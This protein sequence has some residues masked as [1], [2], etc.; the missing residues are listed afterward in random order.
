MYATAQ[1]P[2]TGQSASWS[3]KP[4]GCPPNLGESAQWSVKPF[5]CNTGLSA[6]WSVKPFGCSTSGHQGNYL[7]RPGNGARYSAPVR[8]TSRARYV[9][10]FNS[11]SATYSVK[12]FGSNFA[13]SVDRID[14]VGA[15]QVAPLVSTGLSVAGG[16]AG[17]IY[18]G[19]IGGMIGSA[20]GSVAGSLIGGVIGGSGVSS[21][22][23]EQL[24]NNGTASQ[25]QNAQPIIQLTA[26]VAGQIGSM[27][28]QIQ[29]LKAAGQSTT[30]S[31]YQMAI[32]GLQLIGSL[33]S[34]WTY[35]SSSVPNYSPTL[36]MGNG[37]TV[38]ANMSR[39]FANLI[40]ALTSAGA[41]ASLI[42]TVKTVKPPGV[43]THGKAISAVTTMTQQIA[44]A[45]SSL[46]STLSGL[47]VSATTIAGSTTST[48]TIPTTTGGT[49]TAIVTAPNI[50]ASQASNGVVTVLD[51][52]TGQTFQFE[53]ES[54]YQSAL[55]Y[56][57]QSGTSIDASPYLLGIGT[58]YSG[59]TGSGYYYQP[60]STSTGSGYYQPNS[61]SGYPIQSGSGY[62]PLPVAA[63][64]NTND[65][66]ILG[67]V[68]LAAYFLFFHG[69]SSGGSVRHHRHKTR[70]HLEVVPGP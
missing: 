55:S 69:K 8:N 29:G 27:G 25:F 45:V 6:S 14:S 49:S 4:F 70:E 36:G 24:A 42:A 15:P 44:A 58:G 68:G 66:L 59:G 12:P 51:Q 16:V 46:Q 65:Y 18:G 57:A 67:G 41:P 62:A 43:I 56:A 23:R 33:Y 64:T 54:V 26:Q 22:V 1:P 30:A 63:P 21:S 19:P 2:R 31:L 53:N 38:E 37:A 17:S 32:N 3:I 50:T 11:S 35:G 39:L 47:P 48:S 7:G 13:G 5:G 9:Y 28:L 40:T 61:G 20:A 10:D 60:V 52:S 34:I